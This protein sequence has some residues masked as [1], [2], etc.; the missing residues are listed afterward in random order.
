MDT[1]LKD[2]LLENKLKES[3]LAEKPKSQDWGLPAPRRGRRRMLLLGTLALALLLAVAY[4]TGLVGGRNDQAAQEPVEVG[5]PP[6]VS[7]SGPVVPEKR[8][9]LSFV[10]TGRVRQLLVRP[11]DQVKRGQ[12]LAQLEPSSVQNNAFS[13]TPPQV[14]SSD[15]YITAPFDGTVGLVMVNEWETVPAGSP[16]LTLGDMRT[17]RVEIEDLSESDVGRL[18]EGQPVAITFEAFPGRRVSGRVARISPMNNAKGGGVNYDVVVEFTTADLP[19]LRWGMTA[20]VDIQ[21]EAGQ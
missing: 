1:K 20:H 10:A 15:L 21:V 4:L 13:S 19:A 14:G 11:G 16:V 6:V 7:A 8:T 17:M 9:R 5:P 18:G 2:D 3:L 12:L